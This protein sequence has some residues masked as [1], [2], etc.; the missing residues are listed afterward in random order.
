MAERTLIGNNRVES[1]MKAERENKIE[2]QC[3]PKH[4]AY[5]GK[6]HKIFK[7]AFLFAVIKRRYV[8]H[9]NPQK[10]PGLHD[11][12]FIFFKQNNNRIKKRKMK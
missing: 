5:T 2:K 4:P 1:S 8:Q 9:K 12:F 11:I 3:K 7:F 6:Q 10:V